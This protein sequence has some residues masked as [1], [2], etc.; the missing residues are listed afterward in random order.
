MSKV[1]AHMHIIVKEEK[2]CH[3]FMLI[4]SNEYNSLEASD[5]VDINVFVL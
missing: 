1:V 2:S 4:T 3:M 5:V